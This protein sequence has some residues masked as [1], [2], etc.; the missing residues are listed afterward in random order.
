MTTKPQE[1]AGL[2][3]IL[4]DPPGPW[5]PVEELMGFLV[6]LDL[7][8]DCPDVRASRAQVEGYLQHHRKSAH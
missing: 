1:F 5:A 8:P 6:G 4:I 3:T 7:L 2:P